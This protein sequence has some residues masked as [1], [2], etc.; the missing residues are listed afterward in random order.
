[1]HI[2]PRVIYSKLNL[3][4]H[5]FQ[6]YKISYKSRNPFALYDDIQH[7]GGEGGSSEVKI[8]GLSP[9]ETYTISVA[10]VSGE[11]SGRPSRIEVTTKGLRDY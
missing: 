1:M 10:V 7:V 11:A 3:P 2:H 4:H 6:T 9:S 8:D 5:Y